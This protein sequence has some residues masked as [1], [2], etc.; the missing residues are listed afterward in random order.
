MK[1]C[2]SIPFLVVFLFSNCKSGNPAAEQ[3]L[4]N[5]DYYFSG[6]RVQIQGRADLPAPARGIVGLEERRGICK[7]EALLH[8]HSKWL[9]LTLKDRN[10]PDEWFLRLK[11]GAEGKWSGCLKDAKMISYFFDTFQSCRVTVLYP[12]LPQNY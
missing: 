8:S 11:L 10:S 9:S 12:C 2:R 3:E 7:R 1:G 5:Q 6:N 4:L